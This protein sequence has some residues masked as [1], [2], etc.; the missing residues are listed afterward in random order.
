MPSRQIRVQIWLLPKTASDSWRKV[1]WADN[2]G[3]YNS[4]KCHQT[5]FFFW[6]SKPAII[7]GKKVSFFC[8]IPRPV[9]QDRRWGKSK[10]KKKMHFAWR[11]G[12]KISFPEFEE[13]NISSRF[14]TSM[15]SSEG[16]KNFQTNCWARMNNS[17]SFEEENETFFEGR[18][19]IFLL[20]WTWE[21]KR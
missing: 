9:H 11:F 5:N 6:C 12:K 8:P 13:R 15:L 16:G 2:H 7:G 4:P 1:N 20:P 18:R 10:K 19:N 17:K 3:G 21:V 14:E